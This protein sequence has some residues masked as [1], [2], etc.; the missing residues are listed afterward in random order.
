MF[1]V[2]ELSSYYINFNESHSWIMVVHPEKQNHFMVTWRWSLPQLS[3]FKVV[4]FRGWYNDT[5]NVTWP[6]IWDTVPV[7]HQAFSFFSLSKKE[8]QPALHYHHNDKNII[9]TQTHWITVYHSQHS[10]HTYCSILYNIL[11]TNNM[12][13]WRHTAMTLTSFF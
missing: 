11:H 4:L 7:R 9:I 10:E 13:H 3:S 8:H 2:C 6:E 12:L 1:K 5:D